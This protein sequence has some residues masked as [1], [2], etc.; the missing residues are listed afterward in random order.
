[1]ANSPGG[2]LDSGGAQASR[3]H[4]GRACGSP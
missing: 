2:D 3:V 1:M 4:G